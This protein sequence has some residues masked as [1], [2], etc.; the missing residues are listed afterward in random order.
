MSQLTIEKFDCEGEPSSVGARWE[1]W[2]RGLF[3]YFDAADITKS[4]KKR[5]TLLHFG[6]SELQEIFYNIPEANA[7]TTDGVDVFKIA[8]DKL[9]AYFTPKQSKVYERHLFRLI[10][11]EPDERF[12]KFL[13]RLRQQADKCKFN[14]KEDQIIDQITDVAK[15]RS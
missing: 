2:K 5:A 13:V 9:D 11:Q 1:R 4:E 12:E 7:S 14:D 15:P 3:I 8:I 6:G 10:K